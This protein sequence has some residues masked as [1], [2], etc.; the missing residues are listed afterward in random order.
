MFAVIDNL[1]IHYKWVGQKPKTVMVLLH[2]WG[3]SMECFKDLVR[4]LPDYRYLLIDLPG[5]GLSATPA[6]FL[7]CQDYAQL[8]KKLLVQLRL[9]NVI[10]LGHSFGGKIACLLALATEVVT[11]LVL[12]GSAGIILPKSLKLRMKIRLA[13]LLKPLAFLRKRSRLFIGSQDYQ[14]AKGVMRQI[15]VHTVNT[16]I[17]NLL[18]HLKL[19]VLLIW[20]DQDQVTPTGAIF[21]RFLPK[22]KLVILPGDHFVFLQAKSAFYQQLRLFGTSL[23]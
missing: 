22:A 18:P 11:K 4:D 6:H 13:K 10:V 23:C 19:P 12:V 17:V 3:Q 15:C 2:G 16:S 8:V 20:G 7:T 5:F 14:Q 21:E 9:T 1:R